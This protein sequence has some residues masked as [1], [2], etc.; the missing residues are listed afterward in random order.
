MTALDQ[1]AATTP[2]DP[3]TEMGAV[4]L[5]VANLDRSLAFYTGAMGFAVLQR[6]DAGAILGVAGAPLLVLN[7]QHGALPWLT[8]DMTGL[9]HFAILVPTRAALGGWLRHYLSLNFPP[10]GQGDH[11]VSEA[12]YLRDPD[13]HGIEVYRDRPREGWR[14]TNGQVQMGTGPVDLRGI[15]AEAADAGQPWAGMAA[16]TKIGHMH[17]QV[18]DIAKASTFYHD[19][20]GFDIV[21]QMPSALFVSAGG[22]H[23]HLGM[24]TWH[25]QGASPASSDTAR[26]LWYTIALPSEEA[27]A[28]LVGRL[29]AAGITHELLDGIV[30]VRDPWQNSI[31]L[32]VGALPD[33]Q[34]AAALTEHAR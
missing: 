23:H 8:D 9:Y 5:S 15:L 4:A 20:L 3:A 14:W 27:R 19:M 33:T 6:T 11:I 18:G 28:A 22:Y 7:E 13:G 25:S 1:Q 26:L 10:P 12:L 17:L 24:N 31:L 16:G 30:T 2:I 34:A 32:H 29:T 21:A